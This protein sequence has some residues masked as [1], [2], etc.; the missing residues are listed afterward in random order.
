M[1]EY[2][3]TIYDE[4]YHLTLKYVISK[5]SDISYVQD[6]MQNIYLNLYNTL[7]R[8]NDYIKNYKAFVITLAKREIFKYY[9]LKNKL[10]LLLD[11]TD[12][13]IIENSII[14]DSYIEADFVNKENKELI[15]NEIRKESLDVQKMMVLYYMEGVSLKEIARLLNV[16]ENTVKTKIYRTIS[17]LK[18]TFGD[19][20]E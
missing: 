20:N 17:K 10:K 7:L 8:K 5:C 12:F 1:D 15:W 9:S 19:G 2:F 16:N 6:M 4:T 14:D 3:N 13:D 18:G 11:N